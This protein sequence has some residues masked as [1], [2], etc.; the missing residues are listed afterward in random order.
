M[1]NKTFARFAALT[2]PI[3]T[4][5]PLSRASNETSLMV[6]K[7]VFTQGERKNVQIHMLR[8]MSAN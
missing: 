1:K 8:L 2:V 4:T 3:S 7:M 5:V 6:R